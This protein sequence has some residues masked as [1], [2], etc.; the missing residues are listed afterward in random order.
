[1]LVELFER[2]S[3]YD[4][5]TKQN[6][7]IDGVKRLADAGQLCWEAILAKDIEKL[8]QALT[9]THDAWAEI[10]PLTTSEQIEAAPEFGS[11][12][13]TEARPLDKGH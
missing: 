8:G 1:M 5:L 6:I 7:T 11:S 13:D 9:G 4:P 3:G 2:P 10:L 12:V